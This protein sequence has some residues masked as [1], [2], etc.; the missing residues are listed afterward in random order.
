MFLQCLGKYMP[1]YDRTVEYVFLSHP[2]IDH[3]GGLLE[4]LKRYKVDNLFHDSVIWLRK[5]Y[6]SA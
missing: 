3:Y 1:F 5:K 6:K 4:I 2:Q